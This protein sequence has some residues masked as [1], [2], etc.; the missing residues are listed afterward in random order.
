MLQ[1][2]LIGCLAPCLFLTLSVS[3]CAPQTDSV[4]EPTAISSPT[5]FVPAP[6]IRFGLIGA[7]PAAQPNIWQLFDQVGANYA[8]RALAEGSLL[9]LYHL[10]P[11]DFSF[12]PLAAAGFP[13]EPIQEGAQYAALVQLRSDLRWTDGSPFTAEDVAFSANTILAF[14][15]DYD[16][17]A[18]YSR[19][20]LQRAEALNS[21]T[22]KFI[23]K[24]K[25]NVEVWQYGVLQ[26][27]LVQKAFWQPAVQQAASL[28]PADA[29]N[30]EIAKIR[31]NLEIAQPQLADL[32]AQITSLRVNGKQNRKT[33]SD[34]LKIQGEVVYL[35]ATL[36]NR[37]EDYAAQIK[38]AQQSLQAAR[39]EKEP[40]LGTWL[41]AQKKDGVWI[42][43]LN[44]DQPFGAPSFERV[45]YHFFENETAALSAFQNNQVDFILS[46]VENAPAG[47][48]YNPSSSARFL[49]FN[50]L[51]GYLADPAFRAAFA[52]LI[53]RSALADDILQNKAAP[54]NS[55]VLSP[56]W[57]NSSLSDACSGMN[58]AARLAYA[59]QRLK[60]AGYSW[61]QIDKKI[62]LPNGGDFPTV[63]LLAPT[64]KEDPLRY[65]AAAYIAE[66]A[67]GLG[68]PLEVQAV[69]LN[70]IVYAVYS[71]QK[72]DMALIGW[73]LSEYPAYLC[74]WL[75]GEKLFFTTGNRFQS[76][77]AA[78]HAESNLTAAHQIIA[79]IESALY[80]ELPL[81]PLF[82]V[83]QADVYQNLSYPA[84]GILNGWAGLYGAPAYAISAP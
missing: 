28:L 47:A 80:V 6:E 81:I 52:C 48:R 71:S 32:T 31:A 9:R 11:Q 7:A 68:I 54:L 78:L 55:F 50:P 24:Q 42:N 35:Q 4:A 36:E 74:D 66:Q 64:L 44:P 65:A 40:T 10:D 41:P 84:P 37:L 79:Q 51:Q 61:R 16:W 1:K 82:S 23:F 20:F 60:D 77:C 63:T 34:Y 43:Q 58:H 39:A 13:S 67:Q 38:L 57:H 83:K 18:Y 53:D 3:S 46:P 56:Q 72:Y 45:S 21:S 19:Q 25:P 22:V 69:T 33:E 59:A 8:S 62:I 75:N 14:E 27:P 2:I 76:A 29:L 17:G 5:H 73:R 70:D 26:A 15:F 30:V 49:V 12:Q